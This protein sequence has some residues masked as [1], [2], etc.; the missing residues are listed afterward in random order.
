LSRSKN[1]LNHFSGNSATTLSVCLQS[2]LSV[3]Q[4]SVRQSLFHAAFTGRA[5]AKLVEP[6]SRPAEPVLG[7]LLCRHRPLFPLLSPLLF[8]SLSSV[9]LTADA[10]SS[11]VL[12]LP[13]LKSLQNT[14]KSLQNLGR[15]VVD[16]LPSSSSTSSPHPFGICVEDFSDRGWF[17]AGIHPSSNLTRMIVPL[18]FVRRCPHGPDPSVAEDLEMS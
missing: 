5:A 10:F 14:L 3:C 18:R 16:L 8:L 15:K 13:H 12:S 9:L 6:V 1:R 7:S 17:D 4:K 11:L 2:A